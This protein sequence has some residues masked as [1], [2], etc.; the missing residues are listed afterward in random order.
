MDTPPATLICG[1]LTRKRITIWGLTY[2]PG[3]DTLRR[4]SSVELCEWLVEQG[5]QVQAHDPAVKVLPEELAQRL[6][7]HA[8]PLAALEESVALVVATEWPLYQSV[9]AESVVSAMRSP[10]VI[11]PKRFLVKTLGSDVRIQYIMIGFA[12]PPWG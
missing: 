4:S 12:T 11:D 3:T 1:R 6:T 10:L 9:S 7:L 5:A 2:K 8:T